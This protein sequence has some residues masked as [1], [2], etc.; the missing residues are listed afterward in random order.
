MTQLVEALRALHVDGE[1]SLGDRWAKLR[2]ERCWVY[3]ATAKD[4]GYFTW[5][6]DPQERA[7]AFYRDP[8]EAIQTGLRRAAKPDTEKHTY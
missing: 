1:V 8:S 6:D 4:G 2:G 3:I 5:C 7:V